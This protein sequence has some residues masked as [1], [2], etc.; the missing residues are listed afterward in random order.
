M[1]ITAAPIQLGLVRGNI[2]PTDQSMDIFDGVRATCIDSGN[3]CCFVSAWELGVKSDLT[4]DEIEGN[5]ALKHT[6]ESIRSQ[7]AVKMALT[8][9]TDSVPVSVPRIA[10]V[11]PAQQASSSDVTVRE[12]SVGQAHKAI[13]VTVVIATAAAATIL[14]S[15]VAECFEGGG[16]W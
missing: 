14:G 7:A 8:K 2:L 13:P 9:T 1:T 3:P 11:S 10:T 4:A 12:M 15:T 6:L 16:G 5:A